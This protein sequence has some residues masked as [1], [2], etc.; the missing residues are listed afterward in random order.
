MVI[1]RTLNVLDRSWINAWMDYLNRLEA[2]EQALFVQSVR[3]K[4]YKN[5]ELVMTNKKY[6]EWCMANQHLNHTDK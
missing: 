1:T 5:H 4:K 6:T 3:N 2:P